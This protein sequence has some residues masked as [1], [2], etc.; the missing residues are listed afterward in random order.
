MWNFNFV[1]QGVL[2]KRLLLSGV[3]LLKVGFKRGVLVFISNIQRKLGLVK[4]YAG[5]ETCVEIKKGNLIC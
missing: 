4:F 1:C 2:L 3:E 5:G